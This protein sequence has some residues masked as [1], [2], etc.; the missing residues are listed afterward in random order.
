MR[1]DVGN[2]IKGRIE[3]MKGRMKMTG[4]KDGAK[5][6]CKKT[7]MQGKTEGQEGLERINERREARPYVREGDLKEIK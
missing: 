4:N 7:R 1:K 3:E 2:K 6:W 5:G